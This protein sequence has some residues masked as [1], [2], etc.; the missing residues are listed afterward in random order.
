MKVFY[1][2][3]LLA[4]SALCYVGFTSF[5]NKTAEKTLSDEYLAQLVSTTQVGS[6]YEWQWTVTNLNPGDGSGE[7]MQDLSHWSLA[8]SDLVT[9][10]DI[11]SVQYSLDGTTWINLPVSLAIDKSQV[12]YPGPVL[13]F[14]FGTKGGAPTHYKLTVNK[15][16]TQGLTTSNFKSGKIT[17][18]YNG[19]VDGIGT[20]VDD[21]SVIR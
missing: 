1:S 14:D 11:V 15:F 16:F 20:P 12:C 7:T 10:Q 18:C 2:L 19:T 21:G 13:K 4:V 17:G 9:L 8:I 5:T 6:N 3:S